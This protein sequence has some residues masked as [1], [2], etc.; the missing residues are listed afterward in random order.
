VGQN[1]WDLWATRPLERKYC[2][3][4]HADCTTC[5]ITQAKFGGKILPVYLPVRPA[6]QDHP[7][8]SARCQNTTCR[9]F[10]I[11]GMDLIPSDARRIKMLVRAL[12]REEKD[13]FRCRLR[14]V[15]LEWSYVSDLCASLN[16]GQCIFLD[17]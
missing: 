4:K 3:M 17:D 14:N 11:E 7:K 15:H 2:C 13:I 16:H 10:C 5:P 9:H 6:S 12:S 8:D 1:C